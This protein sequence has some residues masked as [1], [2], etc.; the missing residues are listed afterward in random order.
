M[1]GTVSG[2]LRASRTN[3]IKYG[4]NFYKQIGRLGGLAKVPKGF[5]MMPKEKVSA[6]G[7]KGGKV[8]WAKKE[9]KVTVPSL[10]NHLPKKRWWD[11]K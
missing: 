3:K 4:D 5:S 8:S 1:S 11:F 7:R 2:G 10:P 9:V 6:A